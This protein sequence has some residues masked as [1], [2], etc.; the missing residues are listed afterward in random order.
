MFLEYVYVSSVFY[1]LDGG[2]EAY[3]VGECMDDLL[4]Y[5]NQFL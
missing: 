3:A 4:F 5:T 1:V 2:L